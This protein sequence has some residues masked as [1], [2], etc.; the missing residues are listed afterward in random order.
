MMKKGMEHRNDE[1][2]NE[3]ICRIEKRKQQEIERRSGRQDG[4]GG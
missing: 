4:Y 2:M 3:N 1:G